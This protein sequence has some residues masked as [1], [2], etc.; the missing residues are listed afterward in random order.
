MA[1][2]Q[3]V[4]IGGQ[5]IGYEAQWHSLGL[6]DAGTTISATSYVAGG[7]ADATTRPVAFIFNGGPGASSSPLHFTAFGPR[8][9]P[10]TGPA[11]WTEEVLTANESSLLD[12][13]DLIFVDPVGTGFNRTDEPGADAPYLS[14]E[15]DVTAA[16]RLIRHWLH[17]N[18]REDSPLV[19]VGQS[20]GGL[21]VATLA[22]QL[23]D[24]RLDRIILISPLL[25][26][27]ASSTA[28]GNDLRFIF[29]LP[30]MALTA[31]H[32]GLTDLAG[33]S[34]QDPA[35]VWERARAFAQGDYASALQQGS[36]LDDTTTGV[37]AKEL[38]RLLGMP[39]TEIVQARLR[40]DSE[41]FLQGLLQHDG[42]LVGRLDTRVTGPTPPP[43]VGDRPPAADDPSLGVGR[44]NVVTSPAI[45]AYLRDVLHAPVGDTEYRSLNLELNFRFDWRSPG[46]R[47]DFYRNPT[48]HLTQFIQ[49]RPDATIAVIGG[50][51]DLSTPWLA[52][53]YALAHANIADDRLQLLP[54]TGGHSI[55]RTSLP[56]VATQLRRF[57]A[58]Q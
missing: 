36:E 17:Q 46:I 10:P 4:S 29:D 32:H 27:S 15:G 9:L 30:T 18:G 2:Q 20:F 38:S 8:I 33:D 24:L 12:V 16:E 14:I 22:P 1:N 13:S 19:L 55:E 53:R 7:N 57:L 40:I 54:L 23:A 43:L 56:F 6:D 21:R 26:V 25:D 31:W 28:A 5:R 58:Q 52:V 49:Q 37:I 45:G 48:Q 39:E 47:Q 3:V 34:G 41:Q 42:L 35:L 51:Y 11:Y 44:S 50:L